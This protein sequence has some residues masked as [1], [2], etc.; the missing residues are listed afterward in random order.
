M[1]KKYI[2]VE[3]HSGLARDPNSGSIVNINKDEI[4]KARAAKA[5]RQKQKS[6]FQELRQDVDELKVLLNK[7][8]EKL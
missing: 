3:G 2:M 5:K 6:E 7:L 1:S 4:Q 8:V